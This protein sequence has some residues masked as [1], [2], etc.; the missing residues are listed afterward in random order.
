MDL[1][2]KKIYNAW[3]T[4]YFP[5]ETQKLL[6]EK[7]NEICESCPSLKIL[8]DISKLGVICGE[9]GCPITK[10]IFSNNFNDCPLKKWEEVDTTYRMFEA[11]SNK[12]LL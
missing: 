3:V 10:K 7:R 8:T 12:S 9:C 2:F 4:S 6:A 5:N 1:N 11:K